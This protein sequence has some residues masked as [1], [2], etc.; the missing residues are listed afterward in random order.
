M[1][2]H[3]NELDA[4]KF[5]R[6]IN[7]ILNVRFGEAARITPL[8]GADG[9]RDAETA[10]GNPYFEYQVDGVPRFTNEVSTPPSKGRYVFQVKHHR[11]TDTR[12]T[13]ARQA[14]LSD[15]EDELKKNVLSLT[16]KKR[17]N[18]FFLITNVPGSKDALEKLDKKRSELLKKNQNLHA[19]IWWKE[20]IISLLDGMPN[21]W[22]SFPEMFAGGKIPFIAEVVGQ[23]DK[24]LSRAV[25]MAI[26]KQYERD[27]KIKFRQINLENNLSKL[28]VDLSINIEQL[29]VEDQQIF[30]LAERHRLRAI[31]EL[32]EEIKYLNEYQSK[33]LSHE[34]RTISALG[35]LISET[36][37]FSEYR[38]NKDCR[39]KIIL[40][41][42]PGQGKSTITQMAVQIYREQILAKKD[43]DPDGRWIPPSKPRLPF[44]I[45]LRIFAE[46]LNKNT[47]NSVE[48]YL[49][50]LIKQD[51]G[52]VDISVDDIHNIVEASSLL[53]V[54]DGLDEVGSDTLRNEVITKIQDCINRFE[55]DLSSDLRVI[56]TT[57]PPAIAG[58]RERFGDFTQLSIASMDSYRIHNYLERWLAVQLQQDKDE[59]TRVRESF[60]RRHDEPLV[61]PLIKNPMQ[62]SVLLH[63]IRLKDEAFP[64]NRAELYKEYFQIIIDR[65]VEKSQAIRQHRKTIEGLHQ[66]LAYKIHALTEA[67]QAD[68]TL[69]RV[70]LLEM[71]KIWSKAQGND[72]EKPEELFRTGE[73]RLGLIVTLRGEGDEARYGYEIQPIRE[74]FTA[75]YIDEQVK[76][77]PNK[78]FSAMLRRP[79]WREVALFLAGLRRPREKADLLMR[80]K[81]LD[82]EEALGWRQDGRAIILQLLQEG[83]LSEPAYVFV[84]ALEF[85]IESLDYK[86]INPQNEPENW[87]NLLPS[88]LKQSEVKKFNQIILRLLKNSETWEDE[89]ALYRLYRVAVKLLEPAKMREILLSHKNISFDLTTKVRLVWPY[90]WE[91]D[92]RDATRSPSFWEEVPIHIWAKAWWQTAF[93][94]EKATNVLAPSQMH[95]NLVIQFATNSISIE[96]Y[97]N[98]KR[99]F[100]KPQSNWAIWRLVS[101]QQMLNFAILSKAGLLPKKFQEL[102]LISLTD[103]EFVGLDESIIALIQDIMEA[104]NSVITTFNMDTSQVANNLEEHIK[105]IIIYLKQPG[106]TSWIALQSAKCLVK[107]FLVMSSESRMFDSKYINKEIKENKLLR[108]LYTQIYLFYNGLVP[109]NNFIDAQ[110]VRE[111]ILSG[112]EPVYNST[113]FLTPNYIKV[114]E[115]GQLVSLVDILIDNIFK[116]KKL[117]FDWL[118][119]IPFTAHIIRPLVDK[120]IEQHKESLPKLLDVLSDFHLVRLGRGE[121]L[122]ASTMS[123]ILKIARSTDDSK[124][125]TGILIALSTSKFIKLAGSELILKLLRHAHN[126]ANLVNELLFRRYRVDKSGRYYSN[127]GKSDIKELEIIKQV[128]ENILNT[129]TDYPFKV[130]CA[131]A[132]YLAEY[133]PIILQPLQLE[134][135]KLKLQVRDI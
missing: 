26:N 48:E 22:N 126:H 18:Y 29:T 89:Y 3:F 52:G 4:F 7:S 40:E 92:M 65:D 79:Y 13:D 102:E 135:E 76:G 93:M 94:F 110:K 57:R 87:L 98:R 90:S 45:E 39:R 17:V 12:T 50:F 33:L 88:L 24:K 21:L 1:E 100:I 118:I 16:E 37:N 62:L 11:T 70:Q 55:K 132:S 6:L 131:A 67:E 64:D 96:G 72:S 115:N 15:F 8:Y 111:L 101:Q 80:A 78:I 41:G 73:E 129:P 113:F 49:C 81:E 112:L 19:D 103:I 134:E 63:F 130:A 108:E 43:T 51:S 28:F 85:I 99:T 44:R 121:P 125:L 74:Y 27:S 36:E 122:H 83:A 59:Q 104:Y 77:D 31:N 84:E 56:I 25:R 71:V 5:Q 14:V 47:G 86:A 106:L 75:A 42:G 23:T 120:C 34:P 95:Q 66:F 10:P 61:K 124:T 91:L 54:F 128:A 9:G 38:D 109:K 2:Y 114:D 46:W 97:N 117:P 58:R 68:G 35:M 60:Y 105:K 32:T 127:N 30:V 119:N 116:Q 82:K 69:D 53:L 133:N 123:Y 107:V 20:Q